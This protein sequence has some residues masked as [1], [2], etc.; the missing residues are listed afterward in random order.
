MEVAEVDGDAALA[1]GRTAVALQAGEGLQQSG[2]AVV[3]VPGGT[4]YHSR[5]SRSCGSWARKAGSSSS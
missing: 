4:D 1:L 5:F 2:L 3:D